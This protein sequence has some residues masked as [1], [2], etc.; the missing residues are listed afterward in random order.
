MHLRQTICPI[1]RRRQPHGAPKTQPSFTE[2]EMR[3]LNNHANGHWHCQN[4]SETHPQ[5]GVMVLGE[6]RHFRRTL[7]VLDRWYLGEKL[8]MRLL[9]VGQPLLHKCTVAN[10]HTQDH[11]PLFFLWSLISP[12][13][14]S[15]GVQV[16]GSGGC[17]VPDFGLS[18]VHLGHPPT[19]RATV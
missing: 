18:E 5:T 8:L 10:G 16:L 12:R 2:R 6:L 4:L 9:L 14:G 13:L 7:C 1:G 17:T 19:W 15:N 11:Q 3:H